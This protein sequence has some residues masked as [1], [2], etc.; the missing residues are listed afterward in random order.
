MECTERTL[1]TLFWLSITRNLILRVLTICHVKLKQSTAQEQK[2]FDLRSLSPAL[3]NL[4]LLLVVFIVELWRAKRACG[5]P[6]VSKFTLP[7]KF[8]IHV[9][10]HRPPARPQHRATNVQSHTF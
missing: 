7:R 5:A 10:V 4:W 2:R 8:G 6:W 1:I 9:T 3:R